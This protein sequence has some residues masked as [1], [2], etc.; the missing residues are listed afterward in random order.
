MK[1][2]SSRSLDV[3]YTKKHEREAGTL[4]LHNFSV[5][6]VSVQD[7]RRLR[8]SLSSPRRML[9]FVAIF[10]NEKSRLNAVY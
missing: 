4:C 9:P 3:V 7:A 10:Y 8:I 5:S 2:K 1:E 6:F